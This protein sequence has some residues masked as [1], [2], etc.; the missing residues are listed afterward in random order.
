[1]ADDLEVSIDSL[2]VESGRKGQSVH[3]VGTSRL[4]ASFSF[5]IWGLLALS[6]ELVF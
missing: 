3:Y 2:F 1:M 5:I 6:S 4:A